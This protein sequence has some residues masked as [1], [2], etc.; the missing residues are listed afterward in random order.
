MS[1]FPARTARP[2]TES[3][4]EA[5]L[6]AAAEAFRERPSAEVRKGVL[7]RIEAHERTRRRRPHRRW[8]AALALAAT[9]AVLVTLAAR[10]VLDERASEGLAAAEPAMSVSTAP[11]AM[12]LTLPDRLGEIASES[13]DALERT[14]S[15]PLRSELDALVLDASRLANAIFGKVARPLRSLVAR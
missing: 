5:R 9:V 14:V 12:A 7:S 3:R 1:R 11:A 2:G 8:R 15:Q 10:L 6:A 4:L 13:S